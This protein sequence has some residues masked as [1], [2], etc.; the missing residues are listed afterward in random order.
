MMD[1][2]LAVRLLRFL[3]S[4]GTRRTLSQTTLGIAVTRLL[5]TSTPRLTVAKHK[6]HHKNKHTNKNKPKK[7]CA[8]CTTLVSGLCQGSQPNDTACE[9]DGRCLDG[10][11]KPRP[12]CGRP[13]PVCIN[14]CCGGCIDAPD[15]MGGIIELGCSCSPV[16]SPCY[17]TSDCCQPP[18]ESAPRSCVGYVCQ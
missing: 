15:G 13:G 14:P 11:C 1:V 12:T 6:R 18:Q 5:G 3:T 10:V 17:E 2:P 7:T 8:P 16:G 4:T 9:G